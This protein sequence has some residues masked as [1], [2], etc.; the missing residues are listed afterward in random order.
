M[1]SLADLVY[2]RRQDQSI[3]VLGSGGGPTP[4]WAQVLAAGNM[5]GGTTPIINSA[6]P[7]ADILMFDG[8]INISGGGLPSIVGGHGSRYRGQRERRIIRYCCRE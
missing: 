2:V 5:T 4:T 1:D 7:N 8:Q 6:V 3:L